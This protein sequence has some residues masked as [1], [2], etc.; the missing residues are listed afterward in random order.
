M[1]YGAAIIIGMIFLTVMQSRTN[2]R[3]VA[4]HMSYVVLLVRALKQVRLWSDSVNSNV[5]SSVSLRTQWNSC[6]LS[7][8]VCS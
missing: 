2:A 1:L 7:E 4:N 3:S 8:C 6:R 5:I